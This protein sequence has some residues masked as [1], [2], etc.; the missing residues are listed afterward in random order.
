[1]VHQVDIHVGQRLKQARKLRRMSLAAVAEELDLSF[2]QI[3]KY[4]T[5][6]NRISASCLYELSRVL[7]V[8]VA[9]FFQGVD[10][11][12]RSH[13]TLDAQIELAISAI[14]DTTLRERIMTYIRHVSGLEPTRM[15][16]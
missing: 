4:E 7:D 5:G 12:A 2:Q 3:Q 8:P 11:S 15:S 16:A 1:M 14:H 13:D 9:F 10:N 6:A